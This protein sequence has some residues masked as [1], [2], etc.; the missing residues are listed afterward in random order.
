MHLTARYAKNYDYRFNYVS[1]MRH[2]LK[3][4]I[5]IYTTLTY[6]DDCYFIS[7]FRFEIQI[8]ISA[9]S[10]VSFTSAI[11]YCEVV[12]CTT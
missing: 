4:E 11:M 8:N 5:V 3:H 12:N 7:I 10:A 9:F 2:F 6:C 1:I